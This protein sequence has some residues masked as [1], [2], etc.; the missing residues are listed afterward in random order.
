MEEMNDFETFYKLRLAS[1]IEDLKSQNS[2]S[3]NW[4]IVGIICLIFSAIGFITGQAFIALVL[5]FL[6]I[7]SVYKYTKNRELFVANY[8][9]IIIREI[10]KIIN[11]QTIYRHQRFMSTKDYDRSNLYR[12]LYDNFGGHDHFEGIYKNV[13]FY[14]SQLKTSYEERGNIL[15]TIP[16]FNGL[17]MVFPLGI[18]FSSATYIWPKGDEQIAENMPGEFY[19]LS[20]LPQ[21]YLMNMEN[22]DFAEQFSVYST[23]P[24]DV[25]YLVDTDFMSRLMQLKQKLHTDIRFSFVTGILYVSIVTDGKLFEA[26]IDKP[27]DMEKIKSYYSGVKFILNVID[28]LNMNRY[29]Q[30]VTA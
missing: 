5:L 16:I 13:R 29:F 8:K 24:A 21:V 15:H 25:N 22:P 26:P 3:S 20:D 30:H 9:E 1:L 7:F 10:T 11:P 2:E 23:N 14:C 6:V 17:F 4:G 12:R 27:G 28:E 18:R 19:Q